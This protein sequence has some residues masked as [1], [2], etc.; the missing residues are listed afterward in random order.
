M[1]TQIQPM[2]EQ[3]GVNTWLFNTALKDTAIEHVIIRPSDKANSMLWNA[4]HVTTS[5]YFLGNILGLE[6][7]HPWGELFDRGQPVVDDDKYP[8]VEDIKSAFE[9]ITSKLM[10]RFEAI[11]DEE[12]KAEH[13]YGFPIEDKT[14]KGAITFLSLHESYHMGQISYTRRL[15]GLDGLTG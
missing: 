5:R 14:R 6:D 9:D 3:M 15:L 7:K 1:V 12:L 13:G 2:V 11:T 4:G 8:S 10:A